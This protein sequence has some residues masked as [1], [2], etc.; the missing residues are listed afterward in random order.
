MPPKST[1]AFQIYKDYQCITNEK[2]TK[3]MFNLSYQNTNVELATT[4]KVLA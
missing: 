4:I 3:I 1:N 2:Q